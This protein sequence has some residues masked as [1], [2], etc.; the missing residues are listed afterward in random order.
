LHVANTVFTSGT[1]GTTVSG[2][3]SDLDAATLQSATTRL[4]ATAPGIPRVRAVNG[5]NLGVAIALVSVTVAG[6]STVKTGNDYRLLSDLD[7]TT[8]QL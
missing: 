6:L 5:A 2:M 8:T 3:H 7:A 1:L 4:T